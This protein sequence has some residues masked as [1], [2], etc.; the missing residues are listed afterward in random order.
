MTLAALPE[1]M[2]FVTTK[3]VLFTRTALKAPRELPA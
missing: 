1:R 2:A 3:Q